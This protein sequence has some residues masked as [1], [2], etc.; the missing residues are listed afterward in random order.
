MAFKISNN[1]FCDFIWG[2]RL[3]PQ[4][5]CLITI[6]S[7][8]F[9]VVWTALLALMIFL[10]SLSCYKDIT[11]SF[12]NHEFNELSYIEM[13]IENNQMLLEETYKDI[14]LIMGR[15]FENYA[16][17][18]IYKSFIENIES[19]QINDDTIGKIYTQLN[20]LSMILNNLFIFT[21]KSKKINAEIIG[22]SFNVGDNKDS[23]CK[24]LP[25]S[26]SS[27][28]P[29]TIQDYLQTITEKSVRKTGRLHSVFPRSIESFS[30]YYTLP[31]FDEYSEEKEDRLA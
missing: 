7:M 20:E 6:V 25:E 2:L 1:S 22:C 19:F 27:L 12:D 28:T 8:M 4:Y 5:K 14:V 31:V 15:M 16:R 24:Y 30:N 23:K 29:A 3:A 13:N 10:I 18:D 17:K 11:N 26:T 9:F 21:T